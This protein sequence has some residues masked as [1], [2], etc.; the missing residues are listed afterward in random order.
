M[1][2]DFENAYVLHTRA[3]QDNHL[4][5][6]LFSKN[7][8]YI[9]TIARGARSEKSKRRGLL[10][11]FVP[12]LISTT[13]RGELPTL[14]S[15]ESTRTIFQFSGNALL[16]GMYLNELLVR[17]LP[18][19]DALLAVFAQ[20]EKTLQALADNQAVEA[21]LRLFEMCLLKELGYE[22]VLHSDVDK[23][24]IRPEAYYYY[25]QNK[26][27]LLSDGYLSPDILSL[28]GHV[29][30]AMAEGCFEEKTVLTES[31]KLMRQV[32]EHCLLRHTLQ[33][34][35]LFVKKVLPSKEL[36]YE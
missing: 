11:L 3:F 5:V 2:I 16:C 25:A 17:V 22:L 4:L 35:H 23:N 7:Y 32:L 6:D 21:H 27:F 28:P 1:K 24:P 30:L 15:V 8:G 9:K 33:S 14:S 36:V 34:R 10:Q 19:G 13:G 18:L 29:L 12:L 26:G 20:Y 31:K